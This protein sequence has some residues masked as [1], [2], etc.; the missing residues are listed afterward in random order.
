M[1]DLKESPIIDPSSPSG[2]NGAQRKDPQDYQRPSLPIN[3]DDRGHENEDGA[4]LEADETALSTLLEEAE[5]CLA[6]SNLIFLLADLR[7]LSATGRI[8]TSYDTIA[9][10]SDSVT[11]TE[12]A[13]LAQSIQKANS[14]SNLPRPE[15]HGIFPAQIMAVLL[16]E[17]RK[18]VLALKIR[19]KQEQQEMET[20]IDGKQSEGVMSLDNM[21]AVAQMGKR[22]RNQLFKKQQKARTLLVKT[23]QDLSL[24]ST[25]SDPRGRK[26]Y[27]VDM[28]FALK[29]YS[30]M[31][32]QDLASEAPAISRKQIA[33]RARSM[34]KAKMQPNRKHP[35]ASSADASPAPQPNQYSCTK[36][37]RGSAVN[38]NHARA[39]MVSS[40]YHSS[41]E[42]ASSSQKKGKDF[43]KAGGDDD[44][45]SGSVTTAAN[46]ASPF[47]PKQ[48]KD[49]SV[50]FADED[51]HGGD[52]KQMDRKMP[53]RSSSLREDLFH[54]R[55]MTMSAGEFDSG[56][57]N[58]HESNPKEDTSTAHVAKQ[59]FD[60]S[61]DIT[62]IAEDLNEEKE[63]HEDEQPKTIVE[64]FEIEAD[65]VLGNSDLLTAG[66]HHTWTSGQKLNYHSLD[67]NRK[68]TDAT[69]QAN[70][71]DDNAA[72]HLHVTTSDRGPLAAAGSTQ[73][74]ARHSAGG[75]RGGSGDDSKKQRKSGKD[76][77]KDRHNSMIPPKMEAYFQTVKANQQH[78]VQNV[79]QRVGSVTEKMGEQL[80]NVNIQFSEEA[81]NRQ[82]LECL[83]TDFFHVGVAATSNAA[84]QGQD[85]N[86][87]FARPLTEGELLDVME[88]AVESR[89]RDRVKFMA[90]FFRQD[91]VSQL[92]AKST[93]KVV[94]VNDWYPLKDPT[95]A[96]SVDTEKKRVL[97]VFRG[98][99][100]RA[101]WG[102]IK[103]VAFQKTPNPIADEYHN[104]DEFVKI[105]TGFWF[106]LFRPRKDTGTSKYDEI[107]NKVEQYANTIGK[108]YKIVVT[109]HSLGAA[110]GT[111][112]SFY[113]SCEERFTRNAP[114]KFISFGSPFVGGYDFANAFRY[115]E[116][117]RK[118]IYARFHN[119]RDMGKL[120]Y[121]EFSI[122]ALIVE[123]AI[124]GDITYIYYVCF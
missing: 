4:S 117:Q 119:E 44:D 11:R 98:A 103:N 53:A 79:K 6:Q 42:L 118:I 12:A 105:H 34:Y 51:R 28:H 22:G 57:Q 46:T 17:L 62:R 29:A 82:E 78:L 102:H 107:A 101:D 2:D 100:T 36:V 67:D 27:E 115:Q 88:R 58:Q 16:I 116:Q 14:V 21:D 91:T 9:I 69:T 76:R 25:W 59:L 83:V 73:A 61:A 95:Y 80:G 96:I 122:Q 33:A 113:A 45:G 55:R 109:G 15:C 32:G 68:N 70:S 49:A 43:A 104:K 114:I 106:Y 97:V 65:T 38:S 26:Q 110:L 10:D 31:I 93:S 123:M 94:W 77:D 3:I 87:S 64:Q 74:A 52:S 89:S 86:A 35:R 5:E 24:I 84:E 20:T 112:F 40:K 13:T 124:F 81:A 63:A 7:L 1:A 23:E 85:L 39:G 71:K 37:A 60:S 121:L 18:E 99:I 48:M 108:D 66:R 56:G 8:H 54:A 92:M 30:D 72:R 47:T 120:S 75:D 50:H 111:V 90:K 19:Q 41:P